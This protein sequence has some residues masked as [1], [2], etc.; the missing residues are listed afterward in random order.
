M[1]P[2]YV[3]SEVSDLDIVFPA[4][5]A[6]LMPPLEDIGK[7]ESRWMEFVEKWFYEGI[8]NAELACVEVREGIDPK[9]AFRHLGAIMGSFEPEHDHK[10]KAVA[11]LLQAWFEFESE[12]AP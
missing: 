4:H 6:H 9:K 2:P 3:P 5:V 10:F 12:P 7:I 8:P 1:K 11:W